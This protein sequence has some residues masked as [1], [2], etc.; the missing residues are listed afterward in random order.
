[1][2]VIIYNAIKIIEGVVQTS[3][4]IFN[5]FSIKYNWS[6]VSVLLGGFCV[7]QLVPLGPMTSQKIALPWDIQLFLPGSVSINYPSAACKASSEKSAS[8]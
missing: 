2:T 1:M 3:M 4:L 8:C 6:Q 5:E 7:N